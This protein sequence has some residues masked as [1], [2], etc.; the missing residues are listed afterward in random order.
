V[1]RISMARQVSFSRLTVMMHRC[2]SCHCSNI[3]RNA[4]MHRGSVTLLSFAWNALCPCLEHKPARRCC[5]LKITKRRHST[6]MA[7]SSFSPSQITQDLL[8]ALA[9]MHERSI[10]HG[11]LSFDSLYV[12]ASK[13]EEG[14]RSYATT[15]TDFTSATEI[16]EG[17]TKNTVVRKELDVERNLMSKGT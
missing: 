3:M 7:S 9:G 15:L 6:E 4:C 1:Q 17:D 5:L 11:A 2:P 8:T 13:D 16:Q 12:Q 10:A 14:R